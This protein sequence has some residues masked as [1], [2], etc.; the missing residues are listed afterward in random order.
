MAKSSGAGLFSRIYGRA[1]GR[2]TPEAA[3]AEPTDDRKD[4]KAAAQL[5]V[6]VEFTTIPAY[7]TALYSISQPDSSAYQLLRSVVMEEMFHF[8]EAANL[9][10]GIGGLPQCKGPFAPRYPGY[11]PHANPS[12]TPYVGLYRA[13][14]DVF[15]NVFAAIERPAPPHAPAQGDNY[16]TIA[17]LYEALRDG[18]ESYQ[19]TPSLFTPNPAGRQRTEIYLGKFGGTPVAVSDMASARLAINEIT[20]QGEGNVPADQP[21]VPIQPWGAYD[22]YGQRTDGTYGPIIGTPFEMSHFT[23]FRTVALD[24]ANFPDTYPIISNARL[25]DFSNPVAQEKAKLFD[26]A[27]SLML[28]ALEMSFRA[29][30]AGTPD[31]FFTLVLPLMHQ[32]MPALARTL[33]T[34]PAHPDGDSSVGPNAA[35]LFVYRPDGKLANL[36][37]GLAKLQHAAGKAERDALTAALDSAQDMLAAEGSKK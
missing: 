30:P 8:N 17:Q 29:L 1:A 6:Q 13:A 27:Y 22:H 16:D 19:G 20:E 2:A 21:L 18:L 5:A 33:V 31:P 10:V 3:Q 14:P 25:Q 7:L 35:P 12:T 9:L 11:L 23:K 32:V 15:E 34:T 37:R 28:E 36:V 24:T 4:L 26:L